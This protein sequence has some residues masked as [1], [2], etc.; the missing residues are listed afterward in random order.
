M[1]QPMFIFVWL[2]VFMLFLWGLFVF[3]LFVFAACLVGLV[4]VL[5]VS[6]GGQ[7]RIACTT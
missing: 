1:G 6:A 4:G 2:C 7:Y 3:N 5:C